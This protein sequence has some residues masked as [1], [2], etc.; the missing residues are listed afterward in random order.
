VAKATTWSNAIV[1]QLKLT[2]IN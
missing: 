2:V 1:R